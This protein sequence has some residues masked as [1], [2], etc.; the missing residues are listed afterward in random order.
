M[1]TRIG[2]A[3]QSI[4]VCYI[5]CTFSASVAVTSRALVCSSELIGPGHESNP[6]YEELPKRKLIERHSTAGRIP[7]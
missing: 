4:V 5:D 2:V 7:G 6:K 3:V 1:P